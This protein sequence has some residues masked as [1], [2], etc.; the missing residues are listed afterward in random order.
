[1]R[2]TPYAQ[3]RRCVFSIVNQRV[4]GGGW[5]CAAALDYGLQRRRLCL[6][7]YAIGSCSYVFLKHC[8]ASPVPPLQ[9][10]FFIYRRI[11]KRRKASAR[12]AADP[13]PPTNPYQP[14]QANPAWPLY[15][16]GGYGSPALPGTVLAKH[17]PFF[18]EAH[19]EA[20]MQ[21]SYSDPPPSSS[22]GVYRKP[23]MPGP[24]AQF[25]E[26][27]APPLQTPPPSARNAGRAAAAPPMSAAHAAKSS[28]PKPM[29]RRK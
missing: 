7:R 9:V 12:V 27:T 11:K 21:R 13:A 25:Y 23:I 1:M 4:P 18:T 2:V 17:P 28:S 6:R 26:G 14:Y 20:A 3:C 22:N 24:V 15:A 5:L 8:C 10:A 19:R 16:G 29:S